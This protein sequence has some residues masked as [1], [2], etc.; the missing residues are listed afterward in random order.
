M[1]SSVKALL[2]PFKAALLIGAHPALVPTGGKVRLVLRAYRE[3]PHA[4]GRG[5]PRHVLLELALAQEVGL[6]LLYML[7]DA[8]LVVALHHPSRLDRVFLTPSL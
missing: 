6:H 7:P 4:L 2:T 8:A 1:T 3:D 5:H